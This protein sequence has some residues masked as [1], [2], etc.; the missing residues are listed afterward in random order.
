M[1]NDTTPPP[2]D[3][4]FTERIQ[5]IVQDGHQIR[6]N[7]AEAVRE[8]LG[9]LEKADDTLAAIFDAVIG[10]TLGAASEHIDAAGSDSV[11]R[12]VIDGLGDG[13]ESAALAVELTLD[14]AKSD[15]RQFAEEDLNTTADDLSSLRER[16]VE[17]AKQTAHRW[18]D[19]ADG[20]ASN[21]VEHVDRTASRVRPALESAAAA[22]LR[23]VKGLAKQSAGAGAAATR[24]AIGTL[25]TELGRRIRKTDS[26]GA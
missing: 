18:K 13:F 10:N 19:R 12:E 23:D 4:T 26:A 20:H 9:I 5:T 14:E 6:A 8:A 25:L 24:E 1:Q 21:L 22:A 7:T 2:T 3:K 17:S 16:L 11:L 15:A